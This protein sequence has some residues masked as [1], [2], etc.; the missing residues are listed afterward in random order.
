MQGKVVLVTG[1]AKRIGAAIVRQLHAAGANVMLHYRSAHTEARALAAE[2]NLQRPNSVAITQADLLNIA[3]LPV[4]VQQT[5]AHFGR[6][7]ALVNNASSFF[8]TPVGDIDEHNWLDLMGSNLKAPLFLAQ[9]AAPELKKQN[10]CI[11]SIA[12]IHAER[13]M[14]GHVVYS[15]A[16]AGLVAMTRSLA[17]ELA[18]EVR[19]NAVAPGANIWPDGESVFDELARQRIAGTIPLKRVGE[20]DDLARTIVFLIKDAPYITGQVINVDGGRSVYL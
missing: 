14:K 6:L 20:P 12:D 8:P 17:R 13:P 11:V 15:I 4:L 19:V 2:L 3:G 7:D 10:G 5:L 18:P 9:A 16:K 1:G